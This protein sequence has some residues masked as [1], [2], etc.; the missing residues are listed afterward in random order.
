MT[1]L[2][3][4]K[5]PMYH[6][7]VIRFLCETSESVIQTVM[8]AAEFHA[9]PD[10][11]DLGVLED[12]DSAVADGDPVE[13]ALD[14]EDSDRETAIQAGAASSSRSVAQAASIPDSQESTPMN[15]HVHRFCQRVLVQGKGEGL[16]LQSFK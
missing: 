8:Q 5:H 4:P 6:V 13:V 15:L 12:P 7:D 11:Q 9:I 3:R 10:S 16:F 2:P 14:T 1:C